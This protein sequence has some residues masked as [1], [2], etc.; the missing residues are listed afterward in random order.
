MT[1]WDWIFLVSLIVIV[2][3][4]IYTIR[5]RLLNLWRQVTELEVQF[6]RQ[7]EHTLT[8]YLTHKTFFDVPEANVPLKILQKY[9]KDKIRK[10]FLHQ[11]QDIFSAL[12]NLYSIIEWQEDPD[13]KPLKKAFRSLQKTRRT[14]NS[15]VLLYNQTINIFPTRY[16]AIKLELEVK[17]YFG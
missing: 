7:I 16:L 17:E 14:Y 15:K 2:I 8:V 10:L 5:L 9:R 4:V 13:L 3:I 12:R 6:Y 1:V 11:R